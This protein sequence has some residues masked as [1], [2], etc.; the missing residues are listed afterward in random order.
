MH[1]KEQAHSE[2]NKCILLPFYS[3][4][5][6]IKYRSTWPRT[7]SFPQHPCT[8]HRHGTPTSRPASPT[9]LLDNNKNHNEA[10]KQASRPNHGAT[11]EGTNA[12]AKDHSK[13]GWME[14]RKDGRRDRSKDR[15]RT[16]AAKPKLIPSTFT[17][18]EWTGRLPTPWLRKP[19]TSY[20]T[21]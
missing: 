12:Y 21:G 13:K 5:G 16:R 1:R 14:R 17:H 20:L 18:L 2:L 15:R 3:R 7:T 10:R 11:I 6:I 19:P 4:A 8:Q 9:S